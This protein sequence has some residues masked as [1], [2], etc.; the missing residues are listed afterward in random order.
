MDPRQGRRI[1]GRFDPVELEPFAARFAARKVARDLGFIVASSQR[2]DPR[3]LM[4]ADEYD[5]VAKWRNLTDEERL[6]L[7]GVILFPG[8]GSAEIW[9]SEADP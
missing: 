6:E 9:L 5:Y 2:N 8:D 3:G 1:V 7:H 4:R